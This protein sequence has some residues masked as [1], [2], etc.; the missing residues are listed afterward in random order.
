MS[1][2]SAWEYRKAKPEGR[3]REAV[4][5]L[6]RLGRREVRRILAAKAAEARP[7]ARRKDKGGRRKK[8]L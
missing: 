6:R 3:N 4:V 7:E 1:A 5:A 2:V 8:R